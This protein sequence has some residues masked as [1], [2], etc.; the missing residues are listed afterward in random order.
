MFAL[1]YYS[2]TILIHS[3]KP[4]SS[5]DYWRGTTLRFPG[6]PVLSDAAPSTGSPAGAPTDP[7]WPKNDSAPP[8]WS[9]SSRSQPSRLHLSGSKM[10]KNTNTMTT[11]CQKTSTL[12]INRKIRIQL[13]DEDRGILE[14]NPNTSISVINQNTSMLVINENTNTPVINQNTGTIRGFKQTSGQD[15]DMI[16]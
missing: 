5:Q 14:I 7:G 9:E 4:S 6:L 16:I 2:C 8:A 11:I 12:V 15:I 13:I 3:P 10:H 1:G